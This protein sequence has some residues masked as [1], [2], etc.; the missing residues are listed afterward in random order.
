MKTISKLRYPSA[1]LTLLLGSALL[2]GCEGDAAS[3][4]ANAS[5]STDSH[6]GNG[7][8][9][10][11]LEALFEQI[12]SGEMLFT[13]SGAVTSMGEHT[14]ADDPSASGA[15]RDIFGPALGGGNSRSGNNA[16]GPYSLTLYTDALH[17]DAADNRVQAWLDLV[18]PEDAEAGRYYAI[19]TFASAEADQVQ[20][21]LLG[22]RRAWSFARQIE[23]GLQ[24]FELGETISAAW[25]FTA[26]SGYGEDTRWVNVEGAVKEFAFTPQ[27]EANYALELNGDSQQVLMRAAGNARADRYTLIISN[28]IYLHFPAGIGPGNY[29]VELGRD[30]GVVGV[31]FTQHN[32]ETV[33]GTITLVQHGETFDAEIEFTASGED[34]VTLSGTLEALALVQ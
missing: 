32:I 22:D 4:S 31:Q 15:N 33:E 24:L 12:E 8:T 34:E 5:A 25:H 11:E 23:G 28:G 3:T 9:T 2:A 30:D 19:N 16:N 7:P 1:V 29:P 6:A 20:A 18:L 21:H 10:G 27:S 14:L 17:E 13:I 26:A